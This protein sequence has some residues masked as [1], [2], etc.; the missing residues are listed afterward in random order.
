MA[1]L[2]LDDAD[3]FGELHL[4]QTS[5]AGLLG[6]SRQSVNQALSELRSDGAI[7]TGYRV[8]R[9]ND[10]EALARSVAR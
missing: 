6:A 5:L 4:S 2:V 1:E 10:R 3:R 8:I 9:I 7:E